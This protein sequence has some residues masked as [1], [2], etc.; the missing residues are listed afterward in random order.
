MLYQEVRPNSL[1]KIVG[2]ASTLSSLIKMLQQPENKRPHAILLKGP[3]GCGKTTVARILAKE[4]GSTELTTIELNGANTRGI[5]TVREIASNIHL[6]GI[7][8]S[9]KTYILDESHQATA[10]AQEALLKIIEDCPPHCYFILCTTEPQN[11]IKTVRNRCA[12]YELGL[13][14]NSQIKELL[15]SVCDS[16]QIKLHAD[17][18]EGIICTCEGSPRAALVSL[19]QVRN[20]EDVGE[21]FELLVKGSE[22][23]VNLINFMKMFLMA[24]EIRQQRWKQILLKFADLEGDNEIIRKSIM[25]FLIN[26]LKELKEENLEIAKDYAKLIELFGQNTYYSG[27]SGLAALVV[28]ACLGEKE[29][30]V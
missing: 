21:A 19:E 5:D 24:P 8:G 1:D 12:E 16:K 15:Q 18:L 6:S 29:Y 22:K 14:S 30:N 27:K 17:I 9:V 10:A 26:K 28:K 13:L 7:G 23:D 2:N 25:T 20:M 11:I 4:Y 3:S